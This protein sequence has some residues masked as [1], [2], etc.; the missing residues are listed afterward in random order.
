MYIRTNGDT[1]ALTGAKK[2]ELW[3]CYHEGLLTEEKIHEKGV[4]LKDMLLKMISI[5]VKRPLRILKPF[6]PY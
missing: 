2:K 3:K 4:H 1:L 6:H 5:C